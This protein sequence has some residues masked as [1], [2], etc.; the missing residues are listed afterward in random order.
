MKT[1]NNPVETQVETQDFASLQQ[2]N[3]S[4][5]SESAQFPNFPNRRKVLRL[6]T[7][8]TEHQNEH[9]KI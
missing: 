4:L 1:N 9:N 7:A 2:Q 6:Y 3:T 5:Q 8:S